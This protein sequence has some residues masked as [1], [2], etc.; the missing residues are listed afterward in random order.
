MSV[1]RCFEPGNEA[2]ESG[3]PVTALA[4]N[5][6]QLLVLGGKVGSVHGYSGVEVLRKIPEH[7]GIHRFS[8]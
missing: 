5:H 7:Q 4:G 2:Q 8:C 1:V 3:L 6:Q